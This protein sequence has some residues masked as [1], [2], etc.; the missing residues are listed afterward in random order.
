MAYDEGLETRV[1]NILEKEGVEYELKYMFGGVAFMIRGHMS[2]G[3]VKEDLLVKVGKE[4]NDAAMEEPHTRPMDFTQK[5]MKGFIFVEPAGT[6]IGASLIK[7]VKKGM[8]FAASQ[9]VKPTKPPRAKKK[10][11]ARPSKPS[12]GPKKPSSSR[13]KP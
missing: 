9:P 4:A 5:T 12:L 6:R 1:R 13:V 3:I 10:V 7:W 8:A 2:V 11:S